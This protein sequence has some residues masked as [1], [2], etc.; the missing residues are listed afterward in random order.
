MADDQG[1][2]RDKLETLRKQRLLQQKLAGSSLGEQLASAEMDSVAQWVVKHSTQ[3]KHEPRGKKRGAR[4]A[5]AVPMASQDDEDT[6]SSMLA[7]AVVGHGVD[8]FKEGESTI[9]TLSLIHI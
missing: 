5:G 9:L 3:P 4:A 1:A 7:G 2:M 6:S 8:D